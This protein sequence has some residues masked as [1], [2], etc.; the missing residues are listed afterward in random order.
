VVAWGKYYLTDPD[1]TAPA[2][3]VDVVQV[4]AGLS[5]T[6]ALKLNTTAEGTPVI[7]NWPSASPIT[8]G[9]A[10]SNSVLS[11]GSAD[12]DGSFAWTTPTNVPPVGTNS[13]SVTFSPVNADNYQTVSTNVSVVVVA[14]C[15]TQDEYD[16]FGALQ[17]SNGQRSVTTDPAA[18]SLYTESQFAANRIA[19]VAEGKAEVTSNPTAYSLYTPTS[20]MDLRMGGLMIQ[21]QGTDATI[22]FQPQTTTDLITLP[23]TNHGTPITNTIPMPGNKGFLRIQAKPQ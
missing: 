3:L 10:L 18:F 19:G 4:A 21:K 13:Y 11:G 7:I 12:V 6:V 23:F 22:V 17:F 5:H 9:Q 16:S 20:I 8:Y 14:R 1:P 2:D 15:Y